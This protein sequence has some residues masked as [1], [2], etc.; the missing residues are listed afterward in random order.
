MDE[1]ALN[2]RDND[3]EVSW[4][5]FPSDNGILSKDGHTMLVDDN[6]LL[7]FGG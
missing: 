2:I 1:Y 3:N 5:L 6:K 4:Y 7:I